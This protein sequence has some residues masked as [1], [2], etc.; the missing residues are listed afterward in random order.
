LIS[1]TTLVLAVVA[2]T[3]VDWYFLLHATIRRDRKLAQA[4]QP[5][6]GRS[7]YYLIFVDLLV[8]ILVTIGYL[9]VVRMFFPVSFPTGNPYLIAGISAILYI[10]VKVIMAF[11]QAVVKFLII[12]WTSH[13]YEKKNRDEVKKDRE[14]WSK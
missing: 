13:R 11:F 5:N 6:Y 9:L 14:E 7:T 8:I 10:V 3:I 1:L 4:N 12:E 2:I